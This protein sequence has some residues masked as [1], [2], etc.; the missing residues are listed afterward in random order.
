MIRLSWRPADAPEGCQ[1]DPMISRFDR[2]NLMVVPCEPA[3]FIPHFVSVQN[4]AIATA[5]LLAGDVH[6]TV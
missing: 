2:C 3:V 5:T 6:A 1:P 4:D